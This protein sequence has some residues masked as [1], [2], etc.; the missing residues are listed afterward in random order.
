MSAKQGVDL[1]SMS[2]EE[3]LL[4]VKRMMGNGVSCGVTAKSI[5]ENS[6]GD[7]GVS[8]GMTASPAVSGVMKSNNKKTLDGGT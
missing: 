8:S 1:D 4:M 6:E 5:V 2:H 7:G 3:L